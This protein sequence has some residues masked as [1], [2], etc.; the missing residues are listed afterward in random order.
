MRRKTETTIFAALVCSVNNNQIPIYFKRLNCLQSYI[1]YIVSNTSTRIYIYIYKNQ[2]VVWIQ[3]LFKL[4]YIAKPH[5]YQTSG[6][7]SSLCRG[8]CCGKC[9]NGGQPKTCML[10]FHKDNIKTYMSMTT[11]W[12]SHT[13]LR[14]PSVQPNLNYGMVYTLLFLNYSAE[15]LDFH[16]SPGL[17]LIPI[18]ALCC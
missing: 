5:I 16:S 6:S 7:D 12:D 4:A 17:D 13:Y 1:F 14:I 15:F 18:K 11:E 2:V 10:C 8:K 9:A 3:Y